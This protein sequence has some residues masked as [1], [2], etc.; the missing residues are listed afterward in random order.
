MGFRG[1]EVRILSLR[2]IKSTTW[3]FPPIAESAA[4]GL[5]AVVI[6]AWAYVGYCAGFQDWGKAMKVPLSAAT[7]TVF[8]ELLATPSSVFG[9]D[10]IP[11]SVHQCGDTVRST[12]K[13]W[14]EFFSHNVQF[15]QVPGAYAVVNV[16]V[17]QSQCIKAT[18]SAIANC[19]GTGNCYIRARDGRGPD[20]AVN[21]DPPTEVFA[22]ITGNPSA[23]NALHSFEWVIRAGPGQHIIA[24]QS[25]VNAATTNF[26]INAWTLDV[27]VTR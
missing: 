27:E 14:G 15:A 4:S 26:N 8:L 3:T 19:A 16:P 11:P 7:L 22:A 6:A 25:R 9:A 17:G 10:P 5:V 12:V 13:T 2:P 18:F 1:S 23:A 20:N 24:I 21:M